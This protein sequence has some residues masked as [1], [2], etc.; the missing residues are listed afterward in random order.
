MASSWINYSSRFHT[1]PY[2]HNESRRHKIKKSGYKVT[3]WHDYNNGLRQR[4]DFTI[5][6]TQEAIEDWHPAKTGARGRP[7][8]YSDI[9]IETAVFIPSLSS[10]VTPNRRPNEFACPCHES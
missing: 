9:A 3:N 1:M 6:F 4:G 5:W 7:K 8:E 10:A 2:K